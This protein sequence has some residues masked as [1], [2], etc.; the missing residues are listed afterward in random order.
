V[1]AASATAIKVFVNGH[2]V[3]ARETYHQSFDRDMHAAHARLVKGRNTL[4]TKVCQNSQSESWAQDWRFQLRLADDLGAAVPLTVVTPG[5]T[6]AFR[7]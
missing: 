2:E 3:L 4:L 1:R 5:S 6:G 7:K